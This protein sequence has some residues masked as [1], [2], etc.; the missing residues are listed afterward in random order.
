[1]IKRIGF[2]VFIIFLIVMVNPLFADEG[3]ILK[4]LDVTRVSIDSDNPEISQRGFHS[5][6]SQR[7]ILNLDR[8]QPWGLPKANASGKAVTTLRLL[9]L[10]FDFRKEISDEERTTGDGTFDLRDTLEFLEEYKHLYDPSPHNKQYFEAHF[11][12]LRDYYFY[13]SRGQLDL[14]WDV[15]PEEEDS[16]YHLPEYMSYYGC[17]RYDDTI[18]GPYS[19]LTDYMVDCFETVENSADS[20]I[21]FSQYDSY[22]LFHAGSDRQND[23]GFPETECD[24]FTGYIFFRNYDGVQVDGIFVDHDSTGISDALIVPEMGSQDNRAVTLNAVIA[25]EFGHQLGLIDLYRTDIFFT[26]LGDFA[27]MDN[28]GFGTS[29]EFPNYPDAGGVLGSMPVYP[30]AWSRAFLGFDSVVVMRQ[31]TSIDVVA[32]ELDPILHPGNK[33]VKI[34]ITEHEYYLIENRQIDV[35]GKDTYLIADPTTSVFKG[36]GDIGKNLTG[37]YDY[38]LPGSGMMIWYVDETVAEDDYDGYFGNNFLDNQLQND[39]QHPFIELIEADG[40][41]HFGGNYY[42]DYGKA[43]DM[44]YA[45]NNSSFTPNTNPASFG[46]AGNNSHVRVT[47]ISE[48]GIEMSFNLETEMVSEGYPRRAGKPVYNLSPIAADIDGDDSTEVI[49]A[50]G[51]N[52]LVIRGDGEDYSPPIQT[53]RIQYDTVYSI[54]AVSDTGM[55]HRY[56]MPLYTRTTNDI[57]AGPVVGDFGGLHGD[58]QF[59]AIAAEDLVCVYDANYHDTGI[60]DTLFAPVTLPSVV[61]WLSFDE[62]LS[63]LVYSAE[64][65]RLYDISYDG[66]TV[67]W[68]AVSPEISDV[69]PQGVAKIDNEFIVLAG[70]VDE[71][72]VELYYV[73]DAGNITDTFDLEG[74]YIYGPVVV[75]LDRDGS[76]EVVT[77][78][79]D[80]DIKAVTLDTSLTSPF[81]LYKSVSVYDS[82]YANPVVAD[83]DE[84]GYPD[85]IAGG[86]NKVIGLDRNLVNLQN[87]PIP[88]DRAFPDAIVMSSP[89]IGDI[90]ND[91]IK[92]IVVV[93]SAGNCYALNSD[94]TLNDQ[95]LYGFPLAAGFPIEPYGFDVSPALLY[96]SKRG[97]GLGFLGN[98]GWFYS[99]DVSYDSTRLD[100]PMGGGSPGGN[101]YFDGSKLGAVNVSQERLPEDKFFCYPN[102]TLDGYTTIRFYV[103][104]DADITLN[105]YD[106]SGRLVGDKM[107]FIASGGMTDEKTW[108]G[109]DLPTGVYRC[110]IE[111]K[112]SDGGETL[113]SFTDIAIIK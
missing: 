71:T 42:T 36:P 10:R 103:G 37:E 81:V 86:Q 77:C 6:P 88:I 90:N 18:G 79:P 108:N 100:W 93:T 28:N 69:K 67:S 5:L 29:I 65:I 8:G 14:T 62:N 78:T 102:P 84:D 9:G 107:E 4:P 57:S 104:A 72:N 31:G 30:M 113:T 96:K 64:Y 23:L 25:H 53:S 92:D 105:F 27:L 32:A 24:L 13:V 17:L 54:Y 33:I 39:P 11:Q 35:D 2:V 38:L 76:L 12:A 87:F 44:F 112:F 49:V 19:G 106:M 99:F 50:S 7:N 41:Q 21:D 110:V 74:S 89:V 80:G 22:F 83:I 43:E 70:D 98:D 48:S 45:G 60:A 59:V 46:N 3:K 63:A 56:P 15:Y 1:M 26:R 111:A 95:L 68:A 40:M 20:V 101:Y 97:G 16:V 55:I 58:T 34:P 66:N 47:D 91:N 109:S 82:I 85:I 94:C 75:D 51:K 61:V 52:L 73:N